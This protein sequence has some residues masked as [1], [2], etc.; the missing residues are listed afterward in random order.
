MARRNESVLDLLSLFPWWVSVAASGISYVALKF[1]VPSIE[2]HQKGPA[3]T[4]YMLLKGLVN[5]APSIAPL[6]ALFLLIPA[7][8]SAI[9]S[10][11]KR[12]LLE[13]QESVDTVRSLKW[14]EFEE[15]VGE[16]YRQQGYAVYENAGAGPD[17]GVDLTLRKD[18]EVIL[19]QCK[20]WRNS[21][22]GVDKVRELYGVQVA[23]KADRS[24][25]MTS[26]FFTQEAR[27]FASDKPIDL[28]EGGQLLELIRTVQ[29][30]PGTVRST[31]PLPS[32]AVVCPKCGGGMTLRTAK[33]GPG[34]GQ[35]FWGCSKFPGCR[36]TR[37]L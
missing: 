2:L 29:D 14:K 19:V 28:V 5:A 26:G 33:K 37:P 7:P 12:K 13:R 31:P 20:Q 9:N 25:L 3:D 17:G 35:Q 11:R 30:R 18:G 36:G 1:I 16:T 32:A 24:V 15:L 22:V 34:T 27:N 4:T 8:I 23:H 21:K 10:L 6:I